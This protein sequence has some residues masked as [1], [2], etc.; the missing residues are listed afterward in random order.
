MTEVQRRVDQT[1]FP[2][3]EPKTGLTPIEQLEEQFGTD[4]GTFDNFNGHNHRITEEF[5]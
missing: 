1:Y 5:S 4:C 3:V 2:E